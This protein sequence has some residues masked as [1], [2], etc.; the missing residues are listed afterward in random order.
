[1]I[2]NNMLGSLQSFKILFIADPQLL[3]TEHRNR[4]GPWKGKRME[5]N[6]LVVNAIRLCRE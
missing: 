4:L 1:M 5:S 6:H 2:I 3:G